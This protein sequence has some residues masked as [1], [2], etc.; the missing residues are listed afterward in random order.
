MA[1][2]PALRMSLILVGVGSLNQLVKSLPVARKGLS[3]DN[4]DLDERKP[5][6]DKRTFVAAHDGVRATL[7]SGQKQHILVTVTKSPVRCLNNSLLY[8][9]RA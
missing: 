7:C 6:T 5:S 1:L 8:Q 3:L 4:C 9:V 2:L